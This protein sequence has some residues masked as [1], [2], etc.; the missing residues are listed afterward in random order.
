MKKI[1]TTKAE[2]RR[3]IAEL[4]AQSP[5]LTKLA[6]Q[7][8]DKARREAMMGSGVILSLTFLGGKEVFPPVMLRDGLSSETIAAI[9]ADLFYSDNLVRT[10]YTGVPPMAPKMPS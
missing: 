1:K 3:R 4:E 5:S 6:W 7:S 9:K 2:L 8:I 10:L